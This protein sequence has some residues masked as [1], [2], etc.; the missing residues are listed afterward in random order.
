[1][2][3][4]REIAG[5]LL[6]LAALYLVRI[7]LLFLLDLENPRIV[8]ASVVTFGGLGILRAGIALIRISAASRAVRFDD[9]KA[10]I[11]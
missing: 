10:S 4:I 6:V 2:N 11:R 9:P 1:M 7:A 3:W 8:E 5:W